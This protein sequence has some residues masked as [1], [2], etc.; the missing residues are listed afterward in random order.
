[1]NIFD[2]QVG[3]QNCL[4]AKMIYYSSIISNAKDGGGIPQFNIACEVVY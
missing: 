1:M 3:A 4:F 2:Q